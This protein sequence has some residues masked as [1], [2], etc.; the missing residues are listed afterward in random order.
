M[1]VIHTVYAKLIAW[2]L[3]ITAVLLLAFGIAVA[4][5]FRSLYL[6]DTRQSLL[7]EADDINEI[8]VTKYI[9]D[10]K[11][12][13]ARD[14]LLVIARHYD[15][16]IQLFFDDEELGARFFADAETGERWTV[17]E[18]ADMSLY[19][20]DVRRGDYNSIEH[21][22]LL[23]Y[24]GSDTMTAIR[25]I[26]EPNGT[27]IGVLFF[28]YDMTGVN[29]SIADVFLAT[30]LTLLGGLV[31]SVPMSMLLARNITN[32]ITHMTDVVRC[33]S[34][35]DFLRRVNIKGNDELA[36]LGRSFN[37]MANE[38]NT[39]EAT[40]RSFVA[41]VSHELRSP[42]TSMRGF[43]EAMED[44][45]IPQEEWGSYL[46][47]VLDENRRMTAMVNDLLDLARIESGQYKLNVVTFD[48]GE[49]MRRVIITFEARIVAKN[50]NVTVN[51]PNGRI[52]A[53]GDPD[54]IS[55]VLHNLVDN[56]IKY[57]PDNGRITLTCSIDRHGIAVSVADSGVGI[58]QEDLPHVFE[59]FYK[60]EKA[61]T[62]DGI[63]G[64][65][66]GLS[67]AKLII[68]QHGGQI[69]AESSSEGTKFTFT[70]KRGMRPIGRDSNAKNR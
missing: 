60:A 18:G 23:S 57:T 67:I 51:I 52:Y 40:R 47:I 15:A 10:A 46:S 37:S 24:V 41:N 43:L 69:T 56:A 29:N 14:E 48:I 11:R 8:A 38:L 6:R 25:P 42:L 13:T 28:H 12:R 16:Y 61:H 31:V 65:G 70:L 21:N 22:I 17:A 34:K 58:P 62:P 4:L 50:M 26:V 7:R 3:L 63:S 32:P 1:K 49:L 64:T 5:G 9:D 27:Q 59:R 55:Q 45:T 19:I 53:E 20:E 30:F 54:R 2:Y 66:L 44:G 35:G 33:Y 39:L 68:D 36:E